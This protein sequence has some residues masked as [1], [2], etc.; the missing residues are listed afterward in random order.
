MKAFS[1]FVAFSAITLFAA[2]DMQAEQNYDYDFNATTLC[3]AQWFGTRRSN[4]SHDIHNFYIVVGDQPL[5][6]GEPQR[7]STTYVFDIYSSAPADERNP[8]PGAGTYALSSEVAL[9]TLLNGSCVYVLDGNGNYEIDR[10]FTS[11]TLDISASDKDGNTYYKYEANL[12]DEAGKTHHVVYESRFIEY[13]DVSQ[14]SRDLEKDLDFECTSMSA[15]YMSLEDGVMHISL[16]GHTFMV[17]DEGRMAYDP[18]PGTEMYMELY[19]PFGKDLANGTYVPTDDHGEEFSMQTGEI[20][21]MSGVEYPVGSYAQYVFYGQQIAWGCV[22]SGTLTISGE[23]DDRTVEGD[24]LTDYGFTVKFKYNGAIP[25]NNFPQTGLTADMELDLEGADAVFDCVG[26]VERLNN[27]R[28]WYITILPTEGKDHG[29][30]AYINSRTSN[31]FEGIASEIYTPSPSNEP[32]KG[33]YLRG[34][35]NDK[36]QLS[37]TWM[38]S[39]FDENGQPQLNAPAS[40]GD[41][42]ITRHEDGKTYT[43]SFDM[44]DGAGHNFKGTWTG[45]PELVNSCGDTD[46]SNVNE[47]GAEK[48]ADVWYTIDGHRVNDMSAGGLYIIRHA[49]GSITKHIAR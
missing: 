31:F 25:L 26:D 22:K 10:K 8:Q 1:K 9:N 23:G 24:F 37:G 39:A 14:G 45:M 36:G 12:T 42:E 32:W 46:D 48:G 4:G 27:C 16:Y 34:K 38:L 35:V 13:A 6:D 40:S 3:D 20:V 15:R 18:L 30:N 7:N 49:D 19:M 21:S 17:D 44:N 43:V 5:S 29:F 11:G 28:N 2:V 33:E 41:L 47:I